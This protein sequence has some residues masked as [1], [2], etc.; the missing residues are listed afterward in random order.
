VELAAALLTGARDWGQDAEVASALDLQEP[1]LD[2]PPIALSLHCILVL[3]A[4]AEGSARSHLLRLVTPA[5]LL[6][7]VTPM[8]PD[9]RG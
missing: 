5:T 3:A 4:A 8:T 6:L 9:G 7:L 2:A 1:G